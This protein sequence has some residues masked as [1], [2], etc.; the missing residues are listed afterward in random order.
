[1]G[2][3]NRSTNLASVVFYVVEE[4]FLVLDSGNLESKLGIGLVRFY[5]VLHYGKV[6]RSVLF[7][8]IDSEQA[9]ELVKIV[10]H[11]DYYV[12]LI[13]REFLFE[14]RGVY[15]VDDGSSFRSVLLVPEHYFHVLDGNVHVVYRELSFVGQQEGFLKLSNYV[16][17]DFRSEPVILYLPE[18]RVL[19]GKELIRHMRYRIFVRSFHFRVRKIC[20]DGFEFQ[21]E[22]RSVPSEESRHGNNESVLYR[23]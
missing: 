21:Q 11:V 18:Y 12:V 16:F 13:L 3:K 6:T 20:S 8:N 15:Q 5:Y 7:F 14:L 23:G 1:V 2:R 4:L 10:R 9:L 17:R 19:R 22:F